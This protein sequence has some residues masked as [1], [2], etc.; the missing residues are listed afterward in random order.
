[1]RA[2]KRNDEASMR[3]GGLAVLNEASRDSVIVSGLL[4]IGRD[5]LRVLMIPSSFISNKTM[6]HDV[7]LNEKKRFNLLKY[8]KREIQYMF[9]NM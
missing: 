1:M 7:C 4:A 2:S 8:R 5:R 6:F 3:V 9:K